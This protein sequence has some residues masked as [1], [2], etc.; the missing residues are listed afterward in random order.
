VDVKLHIDKNTDTPIHHQLREQIIFLISTGEL[1]SGHLMPGVRELER[2]LGIHRNTVSHV[3]SELEREGW[4]VK[5]PGSHFAVLQSKRIANDPEAFRDLDDLIDRTIHLAQERGY[6]LQQLAHHVRRRLM[7]VPPDHFLIIEPEAG[8]GEIIKGEIL[9][10]IGHAPSSCSLSSFLHDPSQAIGAI[11]LTPSY[12]VDRVESVPPKYRTTI[13]PFNYSDMDRYV[14]MVTG[15]SEPSVI[16]LVSVSMAG[17]KTSTGM[18]AS[19]VGT[20]HSMCAF[21]MKLECSRDG[22]VRK[23]FVR[24]VLTEHPAS[25]PVRM[26]VVADHDADTTSGA[27]VSLAELDNLDAFSPASVSDLRAVDLLFCDSI[28]YNAVVHPKRVRYRLLSDESLLSIADSAKSLKPS[29]PNKSRDGAI[30]T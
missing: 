12:L 30:G 21:V 29:A 10:A 6:T 27:T 4:L 5:R 2:R 14:D 17:L 13:V 25:M 24:Y 16:G 23:R 7:T 28:T 15:L 20:L 22:Q 8:M 18:L 19:A 26:P 11:L 9:E 3:Y 1:S